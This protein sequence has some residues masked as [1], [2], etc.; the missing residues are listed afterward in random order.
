MTQNLIFVMLPI[1]SHRE[2][3]WIYNPLLRKQPIS[4]TSIYINTLII[5]NL[6]L[7]MIHQEITWLYNNPLCKQ[8]FATTWVSIHILMTLKLMLISNHQGISWLY[9]TPFSKPLISTICINIHTL[10]R[11]CY[12][13]IHTTTHII[14][15]WK[16]TGYAILLLIIF[17]CFLMKMTLHTLQIRIYKP[18]ILER[19]KGILYEGVGEGK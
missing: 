8:L 7:V 3:T 9:K 17:S 12:R 18:K 16:Y 6:M 11:L 5:H 2:I 15:L 14:H 13:C 19:R 10:T 1:L 4:A